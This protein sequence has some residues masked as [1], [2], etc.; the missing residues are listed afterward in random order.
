[1]VI[2]KLK[3]AIVL[4]CIIISGTHLSAAPPPPQWTGSWGND[5]DV[6]ASVFVDAWW[7]PGTYWT[8]GTHYIYIY[9]DEG[10]SMSFT[11]NMH[12][13]LVGYAHLGGIWRDGDFGSVDAADYARRSG[14]P[15]ITL[16]ASNIPGFPGAE[17]YTVHSRTGLEV[18]HPLAENRRDSWQVQSDYDFTYVPPN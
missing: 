4:A 1:M 5:L 6:Y 12:H 9:N 7:T 17:D 18:C 13:E 11:Y 2:T 15:D 10:R 8:E 16:T 3:W 14:Y